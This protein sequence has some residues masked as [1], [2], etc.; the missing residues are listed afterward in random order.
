MLDNEGEPPKENGLNWNMIEPYYDYNGIT[1]Y[2]GDCLEV[3]PELG[4]VDLVVTDPPYGI[5]KAEWDKEFP[6]W[7]IIE[8]FKCSQCI[9]VMPGLWNINECIIAMGNKYKWIIAG[10]IKNGMT[11]GAIGFANWIP[12]VIAGFGIKHGGQDVFAFSIGSEP[13]YKHPDQKP[14]PFMRF[15]VKRLS[16]DKEQTILDPFMGSGTTLVAAKELGR[17]AIGIEKEEEYCEIA[18]ERL[19]QE[20]FPFTEKKYRTCDFACDANNSGADGENL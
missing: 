15:L 16:K 5:G 13:K 17:K 6:S 18:V 11:H 3:M 8:F 9:C 2:H 20:V 1:I 14:L 7:C 12:A 4:Q 19:R 10:F